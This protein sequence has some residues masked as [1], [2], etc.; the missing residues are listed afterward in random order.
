MTVRYRSFDRLITDLREQALTSV[1]VSPAP[2]VAK[3]GLARAEAAFEA[4][5]DQEGKVAETF[6]ILTL[7]GWR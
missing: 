5:K 3:A 1:L 4:M 7:T 6:Q 2:Y